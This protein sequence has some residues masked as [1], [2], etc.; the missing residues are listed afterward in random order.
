[1]RELPINLPRQAAVG[2]HE[3]KPSSP[4]A[5]SSRGDSPADTAAIGVNNMAR[6]D[7]SVADLLS[8]DGALGA[9]VVDLDSGMVLAAGGN[10]GFDLEIA[11]A[12]NSNVV[13]AKLRTMNDLGISG[14]LED[15]LI[16]LDKQ[17]HLVNVLRDGGTAG[18]FIYFVLNRAT[19]NLALARHKLR[20]VANQVRV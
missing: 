3:Q 15:M 11:A 5:P 8:V 6:L 4:P 17:Y 2:A 10:P 19:A 20:T 13:R 16:T 1:M 12:G 18:L 9:A 14:G 7:D